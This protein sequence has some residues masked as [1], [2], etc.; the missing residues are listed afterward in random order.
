MTKDRKTTVADAALELLA[1]AG[2]RG[3]TH[4][5]VDAFA[6]L[7]PGSTSSCC[8]TRLDLVA[9]ALNRHAARNLEDLK[10]DA[11][12]LAAAR[13]SLDSFIDT[14]AGRL[15]DWMSPAKRS[16]VVAQIEI[17]IIASREPS[18][19]KVVEDLHQRF[20]DATVAAL[21]RLGIKDP[22]NVATGLIATVNGILLGQVVNSQM[23]PSRKA[24]R[25]ILLR[26]VTGAA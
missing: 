9:L 5:A 23:R 19:Q 15:D 24:C 4:R 25:L 10:D 1:T 6:G 2:A 26:A 7:P 22:K 17:F 12:R 3:L 11:E 21:D 13:P 14:L 8:R 18:L 20:V 16:R